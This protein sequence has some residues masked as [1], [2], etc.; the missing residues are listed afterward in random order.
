M[1]NDKVLLGDKGKKPIL[2]GI[3]TIANA[4]KVTLGG[5]GR[6]VIIGDENGD[7]QITK[8][9]VTVAKN[10]QLEDLTERMGASLVKEVATNTVDAAGDGTTTAT[11]LF[12]AL[13]VEGLKKIQDGANPMELKKGI[14]IGVRQVVKYLKSVS[15]LV[16]TDNLLKQIATI[17]ANN[18]EEMGDLI[19]QVVK[20]VGD[21]GEIKVYSSDTYETI[22]EKVEGLKINRGYTSRQFITNTEK[23]LVEMEDPFILLYEKKISNMKDIFELLEKVSQANRPLLIIAEDV[24][25]EALST[26]IVNQVRGSI[27]ACVVRCPEMGENRISV[28]GDIATVVNGEFITE[29]GGKKIENTTL[30]M[31]GSAKKIIIDKDTCTIIGGAGKKKSIADRCAQIKKIT[32]G[33][34][35]DVEKK[36]EKSRLAKLKSGVAILK[37]GGGSES[38]IKEKKDRV[39]D[40]IH[41]TRAAR[42]EGFV[43]GGGSFFVSAASQLKY[44]VANPDQKSGIAIVSVAL[45]APFFQILTN[46]GIDPIKEYEKIK[47]Y[48]MGYNIKTCKIEN[49]IQSGIIDPAKVVRVALE[50]A[51]SVAAI[52]LTTECIISK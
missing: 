36:F 28:M 26:L 30:Q 8:D 16:N 46:G 3:N 22:I 39:D 42:E 27:K 24:D 34:L 1:M 47:K 45:H 50:N 29:A 25:G 11:V 48:G 2:N 51:A 23:M 13:V 43:A 37:V 21:D 52:F 9:G 31:L 5:A 32:Q 17:S 49:M 7:N 38:E 10:I 12:Q 6:N 35:N 15:K 20:Q 18:D 19:A 14:E 40:A 41:A 44:N 4:V 33:K